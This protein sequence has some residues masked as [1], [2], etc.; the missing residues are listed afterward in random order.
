MYK[1]FVAFLIFISAVSCSKDN[2]KEICAEID[3]ST[4]SS[5]NVS[6]LLDVSFVKLETNDNCVLG[7]VSQ[8]CKIDTCI[9][10]LDNMM[11]RA[12][13]LF[14]DNG[15]FIRQIGVRG[16]GPCEYVRP[17]SF[18]VNEENH[19][20]SVI[21][22]GAQKVL[23]YNLSDFQCLYEKKLPFYSDDMIQL[24]ATDYVWYN[25]TKSEISDSYVFVTDDSFKVK[26]EFLPIDFGSGYSLGNGRKLSLLDGVISFY[27]PF[28]P[29]VY[30]M[31]GD[32]LR[33]AYHF[34][35]GEE[36]LPPTDYLRELSENNKNYIPELLKSK[37]VAYYSFYETDN[38]LCVPYYKKEK[39]FYGFYDK[40]K[41]KSYNFSQERIQSDL[42]IGAF[43]S[44]V[45]TLDTH[46]FV[47]LLRPGLMLQLKD[48]GHKLDDRL[49]LLI[50]SSNEED[51]P[52]LLIYSMKN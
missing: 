47:S 25:K 13:Y 22:I 48:E 45:S 26:K 29:I 1:L 42:Q 40:Q 17:F 43:S 37:Y 28:E 49:E 6:E 24:S 38:A 46:S 14:S 12:L 8:C 36:T 3:F 27:T 2:A 16:N 4:E 11:S 32:S 51:N 20:L 39:M 18:S 52:I 23:V 15:R 21:D 35:F 19:T 7:G 9:L 34:R 10:I 50:K 41:K 5:V 33:T 30:R 31:E 44:P